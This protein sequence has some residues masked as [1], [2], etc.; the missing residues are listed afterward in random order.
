METQEAI[1]NSR[2]L[3]SL[4]HQ[5]MKIMSHIQRNEDNSFPVFG[6]HIAEWIYNFL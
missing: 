5:K 3:H 4:L 6:Y 2:A 1:Q